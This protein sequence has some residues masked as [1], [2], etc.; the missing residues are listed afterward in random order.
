MGQS[1]EFGVKDGYCWGER[2]RNSQERKRSKFHTRTLT[3][4]VQLLNSQL[5]NS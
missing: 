2:Y 1:W 4:K 3:P 5:L